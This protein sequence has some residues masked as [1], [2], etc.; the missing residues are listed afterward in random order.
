MDLKT[1]FTIPDNILDAFG[2][3]LVEGDFGIYGYLPDLPID[4]DSVG[5]IDINTDP[6]EGVVYPLAQIRVE[7][8]VSGGQYDGMRP[9]KITYKEGVE[10]L[11]DISG[12]F[13]MNFTLERKLNN[14]DKDSYEMDI[15]DGY[16]VEIHIEKE[17]K[18]SVTKEWV[19]SYNTGSSNQAQ[20]NSGFN[21]HQWVINYNLGYD[22][23][24]DGVLYD[25]VYSNTYHHFTATSENEVVV[26]AVAKNG[27]TITP[28]TKDTHYTVDSIS[29]TS[30]TLVIRLNKAVL[31]GM[32][33][34]VAF[35]THS[36]RATV[37]TTVPET[38]PGWSNYTYYN[39]AYMEY[40]GNKFAD[41][42][43]S[44]SLQL[45]RNDQKSGTYTV[46]DGEHYVEWSVY[47]N[48]RN[49]SG[50]DYGPNV[51][52]TESL[53]NG[54]IFPETFNW[55]GS[56][57]AYRLYSLDPG[58]KTTNSGNLL[59]ASQFNPNPDSPPPGVYLTRVSDQSLL[60]KNLNLEGTNG[61]GNSYL[62][63][64]RV[65]VTE[66]GQ[67][68]ARMTGL[69]NTFSY[70]TGKGHN[71]TV[72]YKNYFDKGTV[73]LA[74][75]NTG[76]DYDEQTISWQVTLSPRYN[77]LHDLIF[78]DVYGEE[79]YAP[80]NNDV[81]GYE[82]PDGVLNDPN[83]PSGAALQLIQNSL[84]VQLV[85]KASDSG[86]TTT[87]TLGSGDYELIARDGDSDF[88]T[89]FLLK[90]K[91]SVND[92]SNP[93]N[94]HP[95][96]DKDTY[97]DVVVSYDTSYVLSGEGGNEVGGLPDYTFK[98]FVRATGSVNGKP[99]SKLDAS[100]TAK[101]QNPIVAANG[102]KTGELVTGDDSSVTIN[103]T[104][105]FNTNRMEN[106]GKDI[107]IQDPIPDDQRM[108][109]V[110]GSAA[111]LAQ[112]VQV[113]KEGQSAPLT[114]GTDYSIVPLSSG[115]GFE[116]KFTKGL[117]AKEYMIK[118][119]TTPI[120]VK[121]TY[122]NIASVYKNSE[123]KQDLEA[124]VTHNEVS[125]LFNKSGQK[126]GNN[127]I[128]WTLNVNPEKN[129]STLGIDP[130]EN[131]ETYV[132]NLVIEDTLCAGLVFDENTVLTIEDPDLQDQDRTLKRADSLEE[133]NA[134]GSDKHYYV[135][136]VK[137]QDISGGDPTKNSTTVT[138]TFRTGE[139]PFRLMNDQALVITY[140]TKV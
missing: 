57:A 45:Y 131:G 94:N 69:K 82:P 33:S 124:Q 100:A 92:R 106:L 19:K 110:G 4:W 72:W 58:T 49:Y 25:E 60:L 115:E 42:A 74:K 41:T 111:N 77:A 67:E 70:G 54:M 22:P 34:A 79:A 113:Y 139:N 76:I 66:E 31:A 6:I 68:I 126:Q 43:Q 103:W 112:S 87:I 5:V 51:T 26:E 13:E 114:P 105:R 24:F 65:K 101:V 133:L 12:Y 44:P 125:K 15:G 46:K 119:S 39:R 83:L 89:G 107:S 23:D 140:E 99:A 17:A 56:D 137:N 30:N 123:H 108:V 40:G 20:S 80:G 3:Y 128:I 120:V 47:I 118:F 135:S 18:N 104:I 134:T 62:L 73:E 53:G 28:L 10:L 116:V 84:S 11:D 71:A 95:S 98:N 50:G 61:N 48:L 1:N 29:D 37:V 109:Y 96:A 35:D 93:G 91:Y 78:E 38:T 14:P 55:P 75:A 9:I 97:Y 32:S 2:G 36:F 121:Q 59:S 129:L 27:G 8:P 88:S 102:E 64:I 132:E 86:N 117:E 136:W 7:A 127:S 122:D 138:I 63:K 90:L 85:P 16:T 21:R 81:V 52:I 130:G